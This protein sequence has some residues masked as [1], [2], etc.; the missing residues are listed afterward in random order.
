MTSG[1][2]TKKQPENVKHISLHTVN[3]FV[4]KDQV[5]FKKEFKLRFR[6]DK[7]LQYANHITG[8]KNY[9]Y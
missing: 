3:I 8:W 7:K 1:I 5:S 4:E 9:E 2:M 6:V